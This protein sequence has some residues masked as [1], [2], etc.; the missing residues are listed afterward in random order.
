MLLFLFWILS[1]GYFLLG[2]FLVLSRRKGILPAS[3]SLP[4]ISVLKPLKG[5]DEGLA[6]NLESFFE[7]DYPEFEL[8]FSVADPSDPARGVVEALQLKYPE[9]NARLVVGEVYALNPKVANLILSYSKAQHDLMVISDSNV[10]VGP[11]YLTHMAG[12]MSEGVGVL[13]SLVAGVNSETFG[14]ALEATQLNTFFARGL[15][16][17]F[18]FGQPCVI[19][20]SMMFRRSVADRF[21]G[22]RALGQYVAE[23]YVIGEK[24]QKLG[25]RAD[26]VVEPV[27]QHI[28]EYSFSSYW[29][30]QL[31]WGRIRKL[32]AP[33]AFCLEPMSSAFAGAL[34]GA[35]ACY[36]MFSLP[37]V[38]IFLLSLVVNG[39]QDF[40]VSSHITSGKGRNFVLPWL[41]RELLFFPMWVAVASSNTV[42]WRGT[43]IPLRMGGRILEEN[44]EWTQ[45]RASSGELPLPRTRW[46]AIISTATGGNGNLKEIFTA[47]FYREKQ[48]TMERAIRK[49]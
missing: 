40:L 42:Q 11:D 38:P 10:R 30:R 32:H 1:S 5:R 2:T 24:I 13:T 21:G 19:G 15:C 14:G 47:K 46:K 44:F 31:R 18:Q 20:K 17:A 28:G 39:F 8:L 49:I 33:F 25:L 34:A 12:K 23:D 6:R 27:D 26:L 48:P 22:L 29:Q 16:L 41:A 35:A 3:T 7:L 43:R 9:V 45:R 36:S 37:F 4:P